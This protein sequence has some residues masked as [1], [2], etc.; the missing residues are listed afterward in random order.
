MGMACLWAS[1]KADEQLTPR[2]AKAPVAQIST[3]CPKC[4]CLKSYTPASR[5]FE[6]E[7]KQKDGTR[8]QNQT[9]ELQCSCG[10][11]WAEKHQV[12]TK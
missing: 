1:P 9:V 10:N 4:K 11:H 12:L 3:V 7:R 2:R 6:K 5:K 8:V